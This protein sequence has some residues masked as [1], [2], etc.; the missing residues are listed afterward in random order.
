MP[1]YMFTLLLTGLYSFGQV[2]SL[3]CASSPPSLKACPELCLPVVRTHL[4]TGLTIVPDISKNTVAVRHL[5]L[6]LWPGLPRMCVVGTF[7]HNTSI[8][9]TLSRTA[10]TVE[11][12]FA[13]KMG[14]QYPGY[15]S[16]F[17]HLLEGRWLGV[18]Y[19]LQRLISS[20]ESS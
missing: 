1:G 8:S 6:W 5:N 12:H 3:F 17:Y 9:L 7:I 14:L 16:W 20:T 11:D 10:S 4:S 2:F 18:S 15:R 13:Y 19:C